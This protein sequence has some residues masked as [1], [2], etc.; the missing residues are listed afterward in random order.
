MKKNIIIT[1]MLALVSMVGH[2]QVHYRLEGFIGDPTVTGKAYI[3]DVNLHRGEIIDS[4]NINKGVI[5]PKEGNLADATICSL[6]FGDLPKNMNP[7]S[8][9]N[10]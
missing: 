4:I 1:T 9:N 7:L 8:G 10:L 2:G 5:E 6:V 3:L